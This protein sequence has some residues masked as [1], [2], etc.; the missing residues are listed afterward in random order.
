MLVP[1]IGLTP[2]LLSR[3]NE[4]LPG[5]LAVMHSGLTDRER[6][7]AWLLARDGLARVVVGTRSAVFAPLRTAGLLIVDE[8]HDSSLKQQDGFRY[9]GRDLAVMRGQ[10]VSYT[11][12]GVTD[13]WRTS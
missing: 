13:S 4:R 3:C 2:Q 12:L 6:L 8:E 11:H 1:E 7:N 9:H 5:P 10:P